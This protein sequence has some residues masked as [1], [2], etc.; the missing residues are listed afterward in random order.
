MSDHVEKVIALLKLSH[1]L[2]R[3]DRGLA[4]LGEGNTSCRL[5]ADTFLVKASGSSLATLREDQLVAC[6]FS[7]LLPLLHQLVV[8]DAKVEHAL[9]ESRVDPNAPKPSVEA[10]FHAWLLTLPGV[11]VVGHTHPVN[12]VQILCTS[13]EACR[14]YAEERRFPDEIVCCGAR[15]VL[16]PYVDPGAPLALAIR[17]KTHEFAERE[18]RHPRIILLRNH[19]LI[20]CGATTGGVLAATLMAE[21]AAC[22]FI[23]S[24]LMGGQVVLSPQHVA[25]ID[26]RPDE[27]YRQRMLKL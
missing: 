8:S 17:D 10:L 24:S 13:E 2:G 7:V 27:H 9:L 22:V 21:K 5:D 20:A 11:D 12:A 15:S 4:M 6:R 3:E 18:N 23:G 26:S 14:R 1:D 19:G 25:R 16:V